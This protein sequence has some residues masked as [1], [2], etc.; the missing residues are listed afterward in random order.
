MS[1]LRRRAAPLAMP[2]LRVCSRN[3]VGVRSELGIKFS[4]FI[5]FDF[6]GKITPSVSVAAKPQKMPKMQTIDFQQQIR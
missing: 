4:L 2:P 6:C 3:S 5:V 1:R